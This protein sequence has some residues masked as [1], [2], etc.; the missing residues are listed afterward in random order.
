MNRT[1]SLDEANF[2]LPKLRR[3]APAEARSPEDGGMRGIAV[4]RNPAE[5]GKLLKSVLK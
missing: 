1:V 5:M 3:F 4:T 2:G